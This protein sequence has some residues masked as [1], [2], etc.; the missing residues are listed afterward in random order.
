MFR[1]KYLELSEQSNVLRDCKSRQEGF[2]P[3][4]FFFLFVKVNC[5]SKASADFLLSFKAAIVLTV[6]SFSLYSFSFGR[7]MHQTLK[8]NESFVKSTSK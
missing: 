3:G 7:P 6:S 1:Q 2:F 5:K 8:C 4:D